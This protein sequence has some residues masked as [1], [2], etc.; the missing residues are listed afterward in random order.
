[1]DQPVVLI[2]G[3]YGRIGRA[4]AS[5]LAPRYRVVALERRCG[6]GARDCIEADISSDEELT[7]AME[8]FRASFGGRIASV[9]HLAAYFDFSGED[10]PAYG[11][12]NVDGTRRLLRALRGFQVEQFIYASTMLVH[13]AT[14]PGIPI[15]EDGTLTPKWAYP[16][17]KAQ[18][19]EVVRSERGAIPATIFRIAGVYTD[20]GEVPSL[21]MQI[22]RIYE[23]QWASHL[24]PGDPSHGQSFVHVDDLAQAF[25][26][27]VDRRTNLPPETTILIGE[28][29]TESYE[30]LQN[31]IGQLL[32]G[33]PW[34][35]RSIPRSAASAGA[36]VQ[37][38]V[39]DIVPDAID[40]GIEPFIKPFMIGLADDHYE[41]DIGHARKLLGWEP[42]RRL[43]DTLPAMVDMLKRD[44]P[45]WYRRNGIA[46]PPRLA[47]VSDAAAPELPADQLIGKYEALQRDAH[48]RTLWCHFANVALGAWLVSSPFVFGL[49]QHWMEAVAPVA[50]NG[51]GL[52]FSH[53][54]M[55][56][57]NV[58]TGLLIMLFSLLSISRF[59]G[60]ARWTVALLG[61]WLLFAPLVFWT[62]SAAAYAN[63]TIVGAL[64]ILLA[65]GIPNAPGESMVGQM[66]GPDIPP[67]W[68]YC[69]S[70]WNQRMPIVILAFVGL[71]VSRYL[72][73]YQMGHIPAAWDPFFGNGTEQIVTSWLSEAWPVA[74][75]GLGGAVYV[76]EIVTGI[77]GSRRRWRTMPW[78]VLAF[79]V[80]I[81]PLGATSIFF[82]IVQPVWLGAWCTLCLIAALA[83]LVQIPYSFDEILATLQF[84]RSSRRQGKPLLRV[85]IFGGTCPGD[86]I[87]RS[88]DFTLPARKVVREMLR[89]GVTFP[90]TLWA[91]M[92]IGMLLML[93]PLLFGT[94]GAAADSDHVIG[95]LVVTF[96]IMA[97]AEVARPL[98]YVNA[99]FGAWLVL[100]PW[101]IAGFSVPAAA[102]TV[103]AGVALIVLSI[104]KGAVESHYAQWDAR[105]V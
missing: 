21:T 8:Q 80:M 1:M 25:A 65:V 105:I 61:I 10:H 78:L 68:S 33:E 71:F 18:A 101:H 46:L 90:W 102:A 103:A 30:A 72:A 92:A 94:Q 6:Q 19:E 89:G 56:A 74:D 7:R 93:T 26:Q 22:Q 49:A 70:S 82:I 100:A 64:V 50:P 42:K 27:A 9:V 36:W 95:S 62:P 43:R 59:K 97:W 57:S 77:I 58:I 53:T 88:D 45:A 81:V 37:A 104:P 16:R 23:R 13:T 76:L 34:E 40:G 60:W 55:T 69:P 85:L 20:A 17:S 38:R 48:Q 39:E 28:P 2:A 75:A 47:E 11:A 3:G 5:V 29:V 15:T 32:H 12:V 83:M 84:L 91:S 96:S 35:T 63:D 31:L 98:R 99:A 4:I 67:G 52:E 44:P 87:D 66:T 14:C 51:R 73:A 24:F 54:W 79:G 86:A 41:I